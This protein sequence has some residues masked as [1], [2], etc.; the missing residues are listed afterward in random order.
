[1]SG[2]AYF[3]P[4][5][6]SVT[7][8][9]IERA[10]LGYLFDGSRGPGP[11]VRET[12]SGPDGGPGRFFTVAGCRGRGELA[13]ELL[14]EDL[15]REAG[16]PSRLSWSPI[17]GGPAWL[18]LHLSAVPSPEDLARTKRVD[19]YEVE[20]G[21]GH[22][23]TVPLVRKRGGETSLPRA[24]RWDGRDWRRGDVRPLYRALYAA[25][26]RIWEQ[27]T[28]GADGEPVTLTEE[29][30]TCVGALALNYRVGPAEVSALGLLDTDSAQ[31]VVGALI[32]LP[33]LG[34]VRGKAEAATPS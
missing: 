27:V 10:G 4:G 14:D 24:L 16:A 18:G 15:A 21:D 26:L 7:R 9:R 3:L 34:V 32:D 2:L 8:E 22:L 17:P 33:V 1:M 13:R 23:W 25:G 28:A 11:D 30:T 5:V 20:L 29:T 6:E 31:R 12:Q 19:G